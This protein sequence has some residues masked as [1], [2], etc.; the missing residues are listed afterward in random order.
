MILRQELLQAET[1]S[2]RLLNSDVSIKTVSALVRRAR[3][4]PRTEARGDIAVVLHNRD[5]TSAQMP[6]LRQEW[7]AVLAGRSSGQKYSVQSNPQYWHANCY[8]KTL[9]CEPAIHIRTLMLSRCANPTCC[10][11]FLR[12]REGKLFLVETD[13]Q[14]KP[15]P[16]FLRARRRQHRAVEH[17]WL[18]DHCATE[19]TLV[20]DRQ[21]GIAL[22][23]L[24]RPVASVP[25]H[26]NP[27]SGVA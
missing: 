4:Q 19:W 24:P 7:G 6:I 3:L 5:V 12:L 9:P 22:A 16:P 23:P 18:C 26:R 27:S 8:S 17:Y 20:C 1:T 21:Q 2:T 11:P 14:A 13:K 25:L 15:G 10:K